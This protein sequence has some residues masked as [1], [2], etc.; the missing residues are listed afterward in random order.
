MK[1]TAPSVLVGI[2][3]RNR[4]RELAKALAS[5]QAQA[6]RPLRIAVIDD[7]SSDGTSVLRGVFA[8]VSWQRW[9]H[10]R[11]LVEARNTMMLSAGEDYYASLDD[12]AWFIDEDALAVAVDYLEAHADVAAVAFDILSPDRPE[13]RPRQPAEPAALFIGCGHVLR[14]SAVRALGGYAEFPGLY[15]GEEK[16]LCLRLI[17]AGY[18]IVILPGLHVWHDKTAQA[19]DLIAQHRSGVCN[20]LVM[21]WRRAPLTLLAPFLIWKLLRHLSFGV[22]FGLLRPCLSGIADFVRVVGRSRGRRAP[23]RLATFS[24]YCALM[25]SSAHGA[26]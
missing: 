5:T 12:D 17:E 23:L 6:Y 4:A 25:A 10:C 19:R 18:G 24:R 21:I 1:A 20:D 14:L 13:R 11:G 8:G 16:D 22:R 9:D 26:A 15:G 2:A 7:G 3:T